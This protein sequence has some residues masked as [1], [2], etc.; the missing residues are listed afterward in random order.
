MPNIGALLRQEIGRIS[1][2]T[3]KIIFTP[4]KNPHQEARKN[5]IRVEAYS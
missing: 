4:L 1:R 2:R 3:T 5:C